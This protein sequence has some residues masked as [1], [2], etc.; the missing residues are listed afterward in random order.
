MKKILFAAGMAMLVFMVGCHGTNI[1]TQ[2]PEPT[3]TGIFK[4]QEE[5]KDN[6]IT[7]IPEHV[8]KEELGNEK[9]S[10]M[11]YNAINRVNTSSFDR[12][13]SLFTVDDSGVVYFVNQADDYFIYRYKDGETKLA[14]ALPAKELWA[15]DGTLY[16][17]VEPYG[18]YTLESLQHGD[19]YA[20]QPEEG[21][22]SLVYPAGNYAIELPY[23]ERGAYHK[24]SVDENGINFIGG[25]T[26]EQYLI[27]GSWLTASKLTYLQLPFGAEEPITDSERKAELGW[28]DYFLSFRVDQ[29]IT[30]GKYVLVPRT[31][32]EKEEISLDDLGLAC[33]I[34][35]YLYAAAPGGNIYEK[36]LE[37][38]EEVYYDFYSKTEEL[39]ELAFKEMTLNSEDG[40][41]VIRRKLQQIKAYTVTE[42]TVWYLDMTG[43]LFGMDKNT[44]EV[45]W[46]TVTGYQDRYFKSLYTDGTNIYITSVEEPGFSRICIEKAVWNEKEYTYNVELLRLSETE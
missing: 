21:T 3:K 4:P 30:T 37:T 32:G 20:Y 35:D 6:V 44:K 36:N 13:S 22:V 12:Y 10:L 16:F 17:M 31:K 26:S 23:E 46:Y 25:F 14:V 28:K 40:K 34:G 33:V 1:G 43:D 8:L 15:Y 18:I 39:F 19:I 41:T 9:K 2:T 42:D 38:Q 29:T 45:T 5:K 27:N 24:L 11:K 7:G